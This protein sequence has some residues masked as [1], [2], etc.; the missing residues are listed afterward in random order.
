MINVKKMLLL[1]IAVSLLVFITACGEGQA[2]LDFAEKFNDSIKS[3]LVSKLIESEFEERVTESGLDGW[4]GLFESDQYSIEAM[5]DDSDNMIGQ[6]IKI[7]IDEPFKDQEGAGYEASRTIVN[8]LGLEIESYENHF[9]EALREMGYEYK[10]KDYEVRFF[11]NGTAYLG[12]QFSK[13]N[14]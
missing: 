3:D 11:N 5:Y 7:D 13:E 12:V 9:S 6:L 10:E 8:A 14:K 1:L 4:R 2:E